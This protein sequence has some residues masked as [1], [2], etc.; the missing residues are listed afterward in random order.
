M[1][2]GHLKKKKSS[3]LAT[4]EVALDKKE[5]TDPKDSAWKPV[6]TRPEKRWNKKL[7]HYSVYLG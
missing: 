5:E 2:K 6:T 4:S 3:T 1:L 7:K